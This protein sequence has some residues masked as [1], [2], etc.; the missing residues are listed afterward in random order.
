LYHYPSLTKLDSSQHPQGLACDP[1]GN[2]FVANSSANSIEKITPGGAVST[3][4]SG[5]NFPI[6][7]AFDS[8]HDLYSV[9]EGNNTILRFT[10]DGS[11][12]PFANNL[13]VNPIFIA[14]QVPEPSIASLAGMG[15]ILLMVFA[16][17]KASG[18]AKY[19][20]PQ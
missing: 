17:L 6:G 5:L 11:S 19:S 4:A 20:A 7:L 13:L 8:A 12:L 10:A 3:F 16:R 2:L 18:R 1:A 14:V 9:N 15:A